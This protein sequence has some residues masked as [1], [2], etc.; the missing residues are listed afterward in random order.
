MVT[1]SIYKRVVERKG[2]RVLLVPSFYYQDIYVRAVSLDG[3]QY[4]DP[5]ASYD[6]D[7]NEW[8]AFSSEG[9]V[10]FKDLYEGLDW[11][12]DRVVDN[13]LKE[14]AKD[15]TNEAVR[16]ETKSVLLEYGTIYEGDKNSIEHVATALC[17]LA[18][19]F[20]VKILRLNQFKREMGEKDE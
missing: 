16:N 19:D 15:K 7:N 5:A 17:N 3:Y 18:E 1:E 11:I 4:R 12:I 14:R 8:Y 13:V 9:R 2:V 10:N 6:K 20:K